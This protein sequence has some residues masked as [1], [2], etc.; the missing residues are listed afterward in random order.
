MSF[1]LIC[2]SF[3]RYLET[4]NTRPTE[5]FEIDVYV[6]VKSPHSYL[7]VNPAMQ[8]G[9]DYYCKVNFKPYDLSYVDMNLTTEH[10]RD[11]PVRKPPDGAQDRRARMFYTVARVYA[12]AMGLELR[13]PKTLLSA[14]K[15]NMGLAWAFKHGFAAHYLLDIYQKGWSNGWREYD[16]TD[17]NNIKTSME[18]AGMSPAEISGFDDYL[19]NEGWRDVE[20]FMKEAEE[21]GHVGC[22]HIVFPLDGK[23]VGMFGREHLSLV[24]HTMHQQGLAKRPDVNWQISHYWFA[25]SS[26]SS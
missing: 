9:Q 3:N 25:S 6:D 26:Q 23:R 16:M 20:K 15:A 17:V 12:K 14:E 5:M 13:G 7:V 10:D 22:P 19:Q 2:R 1:R 11:N 24:R 18:I 8:M 21:T 4:I